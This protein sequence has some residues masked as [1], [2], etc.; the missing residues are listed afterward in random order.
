MSSRPFKI[1][2]VLLLALAGTACLERFGYQQSDCAIREDGRCVAYKVDLD[3]LVPPPSTAEKVAEPGTRLVVLPP[4]THEAD[5]LA[6]RQRE[7]RRA[8]DRPARTTT[9]AAIVELARALKGD[10]DLIYEYVRNNI[11]FYPI[12]GIHKG[13]VGAI[14]DK[15]GTAFDQAA[16]MVALLRQSGHT[17]SFVKGQLDLTAAQVEEFFGIAVDNVCAVSKLLASGQIPIIAIYGTSASNCTS[18]EPPVP[19]H[20]AVIDHLWVKVDIGGTEYHFDPGFKPHT[21]KTGI[22][23]ASASGYDANTY[24]SEARSGATITADYVQNINRTNIRNRLDTYATNLAGY[25]RANQP[26]AT[27][28]DAIGGKRIVPY[29]GTPLRQTALPY[30]DDSVTPEVWTGDIPDTYKPTLQI[31]YLG[32]DK[33]YTPDA[34]Y[35][36]RLTITFNASNQPV[37][38]LDGATE[39]T[40]ATATGSTGTVTFNVI[41]PYAS[42]FVDREFTQSIKI[43][44]TFLIGNGWGPS[45]WGVIE[46]HRA[47]MLEARAAG[48]SDSSEPVLGSMLAMLSSVWIAQDNQSGY[49]LDRLAKTNSFHHHQLGI[50]GYNT[51]PYVDLPGN[52]VS[53]TSETYDSAKETAVFFSGIW[54]GSILESVAVQQT[55]GVEAVSTV[56]L[57]DIAT[58]NGDKIFDADSFNYATVVEPALQSCASWLSYFQTYID[59]DERLILPERCNIT[60][61]QWSGMGFFSI[62]I[63]GN[64][65]QIGAIIGGSLSGGFGDETCSATDATNAAENACSASSQRE[66]SGSSFGEPID[67]T[68]GNYLYARE[69]LL[70]GLGDFPHSL[71]FQKLYSSGLHTQ[72]SP[73]GRGWTH[74]LAVSVRVGSDGM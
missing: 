50:A 49:I 41:H 56:K 35:G 30:Q 27:L 61:N 10:P 53:I 32:I 39:A 66:S 12:W 45:G 31:R 65:K 74:N 36:K 46:H 42:T 59:A 9:P 15:Q 23:L 16:L 1:I 69:D 28:D 24:L 29:D 26:I 62:Y 17:A 48:N 71:S 33:T 2:P 38:K 68:K 20:S 25:L 58:A 72:D 11:A 54:H 51:T 22:D 43:G 5:L 47:R 70:A 57:V 44:G 3:E 7:A 13:A 60:E 6:A 52:T 14:L 18:E 64:Y 67:V 37:L 8:P 4:A 73:L 55:A 40:G 34:I 19:L 21:R 63:G